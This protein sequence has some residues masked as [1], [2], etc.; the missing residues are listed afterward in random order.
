MDSVPIQFPEVES[1]AFVNTTDERS[2]SKK[3]ALQ[4]QRERDS[5]A[6]RSDAFGQ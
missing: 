3:I 5:A 1:L 2:C 4:S 6:M